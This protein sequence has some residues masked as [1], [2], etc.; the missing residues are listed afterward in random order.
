MMMIDEVKRVAAREELDDVK[1]E[2]VRRSVWQR[3]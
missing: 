3:L 2:K 1:R